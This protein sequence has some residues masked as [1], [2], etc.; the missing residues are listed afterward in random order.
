[1][2]KI[3]WPVRKAKA[4][5]LTVDEGVFWDARKRSIIGREFAVPR[6]C[7]MSPSIRGQPQE[8]FQGDEIEPL[9]HEIICSKFQVMS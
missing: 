6:A 5:F 7:A 4:I 2:S 3:G 1:M 9:R 8:I